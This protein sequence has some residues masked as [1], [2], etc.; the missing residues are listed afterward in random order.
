DELALILGLKREEIMAKIDEEELQ[1]IFGMFKER[2]EQLD[3]DERFTYL[4]LKNVEDGDVLF[5]GLPGVAADMDDED[6]ASVQEKL[7]GEIIEESRKKLHG[8]KAI[9]ILNN[10][11]GVTT[12]ELYSF[13]PGS[14]SVRAF[15]EQIRKEPLAKIFIQSN[16]H[17]MTTHFYREKNWYFLL[18]NSATNNGLFNIIEISKEEVNCWD[19]DASTGQ[20]LGLQPYD[21]EKVN[22]TSPEQRLALNYSVPDE[23]IEERRLKDCGHM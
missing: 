6:D 12:E 8:M 19:A 14:E 13:T 22:Y 10:V 2:L 9:I 21:E 16:K 7:T 1:E 20:V 4:S 3:A 5:V 23:I 17:W 11:E 18:N 15:I